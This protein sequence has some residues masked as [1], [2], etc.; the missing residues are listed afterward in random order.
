[1]LTTLLDIVFLLTSLF[2]IL[3]VLV[4]RGKGG[5]LAGALGGVGGYSAFGTRAGDM[6][7]KITIGVAG[8]WLVLAVL[9]VRLHSGGGSLYSGRSAPPPAADAQAVEGLPEGAAPDGG[10][11]V[12]PDLP[13]SNLPPLGQDSPDLPEQQGAPAAQS[14]SSPQPPSDAE[15]KPEP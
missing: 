5:G 15:A 7:T 14:E 4:Q 12:G 11:P 1:M 8:F 10:F 13:D 2:L 6:F 3:L 9:T